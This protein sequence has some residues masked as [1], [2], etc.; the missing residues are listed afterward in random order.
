[1]VLT[2]PLSADIQSSYEYTAQ[3]AARHSYTVSASES[4]Q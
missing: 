4:L 3:S 1:M 2:S